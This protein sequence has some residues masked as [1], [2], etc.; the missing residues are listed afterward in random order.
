MMK[1][2][3]ERK[4]RRGRSILRSVLAC[5][6]T[7]DWDDDGKWVVVR[8]RCLRFYKRSEDCLTLNNNSDESILNCRFAVDGYPTRLIST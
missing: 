4:E 6:S 5:V 3:Y 2:Y 1:L 8:T 7:L